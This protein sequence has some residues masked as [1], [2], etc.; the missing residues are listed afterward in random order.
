MGE[1]SDHDSSA[2]AG[3]QEHDHS[4]HGDDAQ[5]FSLMQ[6][7]GR[8]HPMVVHFPIALLLMAAAAELL[9]IL[10]SASQFAFAARF[11]LWGGAASA[12]LAA[13]LGWVDAQGVVESYTG[14]AERVLYFHRWVGVSTALVAGLTLLT[15]ELSARSSDGQWKRAYRGLLFFCALLVSVAGHLGAS[16]IYGWEYLSW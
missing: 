6:W 10:T 13:A 4:D 14:F 9:L 8:F 12:M 1:H 5:S 3:E 2:V 11:C 7:L 16:L 15:G